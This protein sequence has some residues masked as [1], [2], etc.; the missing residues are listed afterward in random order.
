[1]GGSRGT[2]LHTGRVITMLALNREKF[3]A[4]IR[5]FPVFSLFKMVIS[6]LVCKTVLV[7]AGHTTGM[8]TYA[9]CFINHHSISWHCL[10]SHLG[11]ILPLTPSLS[12]QGRGM[13]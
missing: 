2:D 5:E 12:L 9:L 3:A 7:M 11:L 13:G 1:M 6:L 10:L 8:T 4:V